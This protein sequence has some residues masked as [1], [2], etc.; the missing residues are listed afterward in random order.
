MT[1]ITF[2][3]ETVRFV[4]RVAGIIIHNNKLLVMKDENSPYYY[5]PGGKV[6]LQELSADA[7]KREIREEINIDVRVK[8]MLWIVENFFKDDESGENFHEIGF[9]Y[10]LELNDEK[11]FE[12]GNEF[13]MTEGGK[14]RLVFYWKPLEE[15]KDLYLYPLFI[16]EN[17]LKLPNS[18]NHIVEN[19]Y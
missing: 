19:K 8:R 3:T 17:I 11:I 16:K 12:K 18:I 5:I 4:Y 2:K 13:I 14:H 1:D 15:I 6:G 9:Y 10:L 7:I